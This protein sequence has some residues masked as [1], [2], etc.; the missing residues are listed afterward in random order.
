MPFGIPDSGNGYVCLNCTRETALSQNLMSGYG[1]EWSRKPPFTV[2]DDWLSPSLTDRKSRHN[3]NDSRL[4][5]AYC[6]AYCRLMLYSIGLFVFLNV[7]PICIGSYFCIFSEERFSSHSVILQ[8]VH[9]PCSHIPIAVVKHFTVVTGVPSCQNLG[10]AVRDAVINTLQALHRS[11]CGVKI[12]R[13]GE[14][15]GWC[16]N[17]RRVG[18]PHKMCIRDSS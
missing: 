18:F 15:Q 14:Q 6:L 17:Q 2:M 7:L 13:R 8:P 5:M 10:D 1:L 11:D 3:K 4:N 9:E 12:A 16:L